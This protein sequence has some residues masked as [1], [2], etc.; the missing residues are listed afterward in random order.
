MRAN[1]ILRLPL[2]YDANDTADSKGEMYF[3]RAIKKSLRSGF[4]RTPD[5]RQEI[6]STKSDYIGLDA[7]TEVVFMDQNPMLLERLA[8]KDAII[9]ELTAELN[10]F[11]R[12]SWFEFDSLD[13]PDDYYEND[14][15][16]DR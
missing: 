10:E 8:D 6:E 9:K 11:K 16:S 3:Q 13:L 15:Y 4:A 12:I 1:P 14:A 7:I 5:Y 2:N